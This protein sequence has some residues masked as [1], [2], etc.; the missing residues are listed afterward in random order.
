MNK[1]N[2]VPIL[3]ATNIFMFAITI[4]FYALADL[5]RTDNQYLKERI[6]L[7]EMRIKM[8]EEQIRRDLLSPMTSI[9]S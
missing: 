7:N 8:I 4:I 1:I 5:Q 6:I 9:T 3:V 2:W